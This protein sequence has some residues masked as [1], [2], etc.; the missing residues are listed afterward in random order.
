MVLNARA[1][2][3]STAPRHRRWHI[4]AITWAAL[5]AQPHTPR[6]L[7]TARRLHAHLPAAALRTRGARLTVT[8]GV[9]TALLARNRPDAEAYFPG[10]LASPF[11]AADGWPTAGARRSRLGLP[12]CRTQPR[13]S[14]RARGGQL[15]RPAPRDSPAG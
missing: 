15:Q 12:R 3:P 13:R 14:Q 10:V 5:A 7:T 11:A 8:T 9:H 4:V 1:S 2:A 6:L